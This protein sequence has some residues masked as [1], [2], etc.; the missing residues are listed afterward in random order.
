[1]ITITHYDNIDKPMEV[2]SNVLNFDFTNTN[3]CQQLKIS[4]DQFEVTFDKKDVHSLSDV[5]YNFL[6]S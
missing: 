1:M 5:I 3:K 6:N 2:R 4:T